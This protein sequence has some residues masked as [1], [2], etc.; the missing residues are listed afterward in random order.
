MWCTKGSVRLLIIII[1]RKY[2]SLEIYSLHN[3][4]PCFFEPLKISFAATLYQDSKG[5]GGVKRC[6]ISYTTF[7]LRLAA[8]VEI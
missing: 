8:F 2:Y 4:S 1:S 3:S 6:D 5:G 7:L